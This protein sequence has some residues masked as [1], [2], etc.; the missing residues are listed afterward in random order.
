MFIE[1]F[2]DN[3]CLVTR[4]SDYSGGTHTVRIPLPEHE[5]RKVLDPKRPCIQDLF[6]TLHRAEREFLMTGIT[7]DEWD[8]VCGGFEE[9]DADEYEVDE[10]ELTEAL[11]RV[12]ASTTSASFLQERV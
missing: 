4:T 6:P 1:H 11:A 7:A 3:H 9:P 12:R 2:D 5:V 8:E 10:A